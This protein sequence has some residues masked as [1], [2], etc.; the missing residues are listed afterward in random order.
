MSPKSL[1]EWSGEYQQRRSLPVLAR[2]Q[3]LKDNTCT[4]GFMTEEHTTIPP[5][6]SSRS[7]EVSQ[8][9]SH[10]DP[11][12]RHDIVPMPDMW[13]A[14]SAGILA[15]RR[16]NFGPAVYRWFSAS[17]FSAWHFS[18]TGGAY[19]VGHKVSLLAYR[20]RIHRRGV[21]Y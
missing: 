6:R 5:L 20:V 8:L 2:L 17:P 1:V 4:L 10:V 9:P 15:L 21:L 3:V 7:W 13:I 19:I 14:L 18:R 11:S 16:V 12:F